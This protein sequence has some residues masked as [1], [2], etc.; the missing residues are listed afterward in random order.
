MQL[1]NKAA[2][3][4]WIRTGER[5]LR[6]LESPESPLTCR[7][8]SPLLDLLQVLPPHLL[9]PADLAGLTFAE[10]AKATNGF[11]ERNLVG[12][13]GFG[14]V[15]CG[16][17]A[18]GSMVAVKKMLDPDL[19]RNLVPLRGCCIADDDIEEG[20]QRFL[21]YDFMPNSALE[22]FIY[23]NKEAAASRTCITARCARVADFGSPRSGV[24]EKFVLVGI[25][26][27]HVM[28]ALRPTI[29]DA[30][31]MLEGDMDVPELPDR[32]LPYG[33]SLMFSEAGS[34]FSASPAFS[35]PLAPFI[36]LVL[37]SGRAS[38]G[39]DLYQAITTEY[40]PIEEMFVS[41]SLKTELCMEPKDF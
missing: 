12:R 8:G 5:E 2:A 1:K 7:S 37:A 10:L 38:L 33:H 6:Q 18:D 11:A 25:L 23:R 31:R 9:A 34:I 32:P 28:V 17:L 22:D 39:E 4:K 36:T 30:L 29:G 26:C 35:G 3:E 24:M 14:A 16:V 21:V 15:Y 19:D 41:L 13:G 40:I 27:A 20:K